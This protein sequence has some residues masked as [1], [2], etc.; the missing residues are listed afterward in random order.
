MKEEINMSKLRTVPVTCPKCG[1]QHD[2]TIWDSMNTMID[3]ELKQGVRDGSAFQFR[4]PTCGESSNVNYGF[5]YHQMEDQIMVWYVMSEEDEREAMKALEV[6]KASLFGN[7]MG[8]YLNRIV[9]SRNDFREK[10]YIFD[11]G[12]DD[13][14]IEIAK[15]ILLSTDPG[16]F[17]KREVEAFYYRE[18]SDQGVQIFIDGKYEGLFNLPQELYDT[19]RDSYKDKLPDLRKDGPVIDRDWA[20]AFLNSTRN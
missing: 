20:M 15:L 18:G 14:I 10:L 19:I 4:C 8:N 11:A 7:F 1:R 9:R 16:R 2:F 5:L 3:P 13:R 6:Q 12:L 17:S